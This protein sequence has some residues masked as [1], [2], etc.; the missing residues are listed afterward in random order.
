MG[1]VTEGWRR[2]VSLLR[3]G[4]IEQGLDDE[5]RFHV[6]QQTE[7]NRR[8]GMTPDD[9]RRHALLA[10]GGVEQARERTRDEF[11]A[12]G[13]EDVWRD[14]RVGGR[15]LLRAPGFSVIVILTLALGI[16]A[17]T[18]IFSVVNAV[19]LRPLPYPRADRIVAVTNYWKQSSQRAHT[20]L[21]PVLD[22]L[23][24]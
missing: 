17:T 19:L 1:M 12:R 8:A 21:R 10:F 4:S 7:K 15:A 9:A 13:L 2:L 22:A 11:R 20:A 3:R 18:A 14:L 5:L 23:T 24:P 6:E 16:G